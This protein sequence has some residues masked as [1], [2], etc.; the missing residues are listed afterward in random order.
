MN[1]TYWIINVFSSED[2]Q[3]FGRGDYQ[4]R[5][6]Y[7]YWQQ[8]LEF[9]IQPRQFDLGLL[10]VNVTGFCEKKRDLPESQPICPGLAK[11]MTEESKHPETRRSHLKNFN[12][13]RLGTLACRCGGSDYS[14]KHWKFS[15]KK[16]EIGRK[17]DLKLM[18][19]ILLIHCHNMP[20]LSCGQM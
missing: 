6:W 2:L 17:V 4:R 3:L 18:L 19:E 1:E 12:D 11:H 14:P 10:D 15:S 7:S 20:F 5:K 16:V 13:P 9:S 8:F